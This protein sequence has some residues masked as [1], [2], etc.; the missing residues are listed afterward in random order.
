MSFGLGHTVLD[1]NHIRIRSPDSGGT[2][3]PS[4]PEWTIGDSRNP[5]P[6]YVVLMEWMVS[7][8]FQPPILRNTTLSPQLQHT[9]LLLSNIPQYLSRWECIN[10]QLLIC[11]YN[12]LYKG[13]FLACE[14]LLKN[15]H[16]SWRH[17]R[18]SGLKSS[19]MLYCVN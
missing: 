1:P 16:W 18:D 6:L 8:H 2:L 10:C 9:L 17:S 14:R 11:R 4:W 5:F 19:E 13:T 7:V 3:P 15:H 12:S